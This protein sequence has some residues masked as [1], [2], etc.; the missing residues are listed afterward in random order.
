MDNLI[1]CDGCPEEETCPY[2]EEATSVCLL[3]LIEE[4]EQWGRHLP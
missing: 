2:A 1:I 3:D 4:E